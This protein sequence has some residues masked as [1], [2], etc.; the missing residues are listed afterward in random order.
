MAFAAALYN[1]AGAFK[2]SVLVLLIFAAGFGAAT[3]RTHNI[4][5]PIITEKISATEITGTVSQIEKL[6]EG[7]GSRMVLDVMDIEDLGRRQN[8]R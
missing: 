3:Y 7:Q 8:T 5:T 4:A 1:I 6:D 2:P